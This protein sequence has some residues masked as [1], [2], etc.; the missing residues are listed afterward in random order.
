MKLTLVF[1]SVRA[2]MMGFKRASW[3]VF[4]LS[5]LRTESYLDL[6][7]ANEAPS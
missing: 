4:S 6:S 5:L 3:E 7:W 2:V 1:N